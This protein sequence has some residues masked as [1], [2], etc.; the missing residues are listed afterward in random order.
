MRTL[1]LLRVALPLL[2]VAAPVLVVSPAQADVGRLSV[3]S[4]T[5]EFGP[6]TTLRGVTV[7]CAPDER[8]VSGGY[9]GG[10]PQLRIVASHPSDDQGTP[11]GDGAGLRAWTVGVVNTGQAVHTLRVFAT[12]LAGGDSTAGVYEGFQSEPSDRSVEAVCPRGTVR[13]GGGYWA[14][15]YARLGAARIDGSHPIGERGW[16]LDLTV[17]ANLPARSSVTALVVCHTGPVVAV[18]AEPAEFDLQSASPSCVVGA[19]ANVCVVP[20]SGTG[21]AR[22]PD[23]RLLTGGGY[24]IVSGGPLAGQATLVDGPASA[25]AWSVGLS[26]TSAQ[27]TRVRVRVEPVC[28]GSIAGPSEPV[29]DLLPDR[30]ARLNRALA[31]GG[32]MLG[33]LLLILLVALALRRAGRRSTP[34]VPGIEVVVRTTRFRYRDDLYREDV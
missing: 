20:R 10:D 25:G 23:G 32:G 5:A 11:A 6:G 17:P 21:A 9:E 14:V 7:P 24:R 2:A 16:A 4:R 29:S 3:H 34:R 1:V 12:C 30:G 13:T 33:L 31:L 15:W 18:A 26:G 8:L 19:A 27:A 28:L 22:C